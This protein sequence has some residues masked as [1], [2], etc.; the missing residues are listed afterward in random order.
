MSPFRLVACLA[1]L[2]VVGDSMSEEAAAAPIPPTVST[3]SQPRK[4][5]LEDA[6]RFAHQRGRDKKN[7]DEELELLAKSL[8]NTRRN[9]APQPTGSITAGANGRGSGSPSEHEGGTL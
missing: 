2:L 5:T 4:L 9:F 6:L 7:R 8:R 3:G 1:C